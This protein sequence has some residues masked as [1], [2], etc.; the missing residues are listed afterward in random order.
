MAHFTVWHNEGLIP[1]LP[2]WNKTNPLAHPNA[3]AP[4]KPDFTFDFGTHIVIVEL[5]EHQHEYYSATPR[6]DM[7]RTANIIGGYV[8]ADIGLLPV[9]LIRINPDKFTVAGVQK[10][11]PIETRL[12]VLQARLGLALIQEGTNNHR[13]VIEKLF[14]DQDAESN[15]PH[16]LV[17]TWP[18]L[19]EFNAYIDEHFP[20]E[21]AQ[22]LKDN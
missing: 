20:L 12:R 21:N 9:H 4:Y 8:T 22:I 6:C 1:A 16:I 13:V 15:P 11:I 10:D 7:L 17:Q 18:T 3:C 5:D 19:L 14:F 2:T